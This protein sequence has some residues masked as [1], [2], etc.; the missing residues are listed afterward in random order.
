M[1]KQSPLNVKQI[2]RDRPSGFIGYFLPLLVL[3]SEN[4]KIIDVLDLFGLDRLEEAIERLGGSRVEVPTWATF[5]TLVEDAYLLTKFDSFTDLEIDRN[6]LS[7]EF[8]GTP[9]NALRERAKALR[10]SISGRNVRAKFPGEKAAKEY[11]AMLK[12]IEK[13][14]NDV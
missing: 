8:G 6:A 14:L 3:S 10:A 9:F 12:E 13:D 4:D 1:S 11:L 7:A 5:D 2:L